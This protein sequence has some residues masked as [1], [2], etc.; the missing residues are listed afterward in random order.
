MLTWPPTALANL[1]QSWCLSKTHHN[2]KMW[3]FIW[4][5]PQ[6]KHPKHNCWLSFSSS[7]ERRC[8]AARIRDERAG[9]ILS[10]RGRSIH[11]L[12]LCSKWCIGSWQMWVSFI[13]QN[14]NHRL[15]S[16]PRIW[17]L[18]RRRQGETPG[19]AKCQIVGGFSYDY[20]I[21]EI[22]DK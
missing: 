20:F 13:G 7:T 10:R 22:S 15:Q 5:L 4:A 1:F 6:S 21:L 17:G 8:V 11:H 2:W 9:V 19:K 12:P 18:E 16:E 3:H 14:D